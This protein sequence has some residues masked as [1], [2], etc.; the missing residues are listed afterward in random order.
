MEVITVNPRECTRWPLAD[1]SGFEFGDLHSL[2]E[3]IKKKWTNRTYF[4]KT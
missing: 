3:D 4:S 1:R 2:A